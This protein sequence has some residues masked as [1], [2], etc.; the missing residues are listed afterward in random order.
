MTTLPIITNFVPV[1]QRKYQP[2]V[3][4]HFRAHLPRRGILSGQTPTLAHPEGSKR[5]QTFFE[6]VCAILRSPAH[7]AA[8]YLIDPPAFYLISFGGH[9]SI[10]S[11]VRLRWGRSAPLK[12]RIDSSRWGREVS[13]H[14]F[15]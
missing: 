7:P 5:P 3:D 12:A 11:G 14:S 15:S 1:F 8:I 10:V 4:A 9:V 6:V 2:S 13:Y